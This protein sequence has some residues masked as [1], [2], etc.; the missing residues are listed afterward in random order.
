MGDAPWDRFEGEQFRDELTKYK[1]ANH[2]FKTHPFFAELERGA[3]PKPVVQAWVKQFYPWLAS[4]PV[5]MAERF[6]NCSW[7]ASNDRYRRMILD[8]LVEEAGDPKGKEPGHP[9]LWLRFCEGIGVPRAEV[10][11]A[12]LLPSTMVAIDDFLYTNRIN[13]FFVSAAGS[14]EP[15]NVDLCARLLPAFR[16]HYA[17]PEENLEY[18]R[19]H[20][21]ADVEHS[22]W[23]GQI[24]AGF[25]NNASVRKQMW[26]QMLRGFSIHALLVDGVAQT[27]G[28]SPAAGKHK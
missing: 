25:A 14:S 18:Y 21:T 12:S 23:I 19:L 20:V 2:P 17:V 7:E 6:A 11:S 5:A 16:T 28:W 15:P 4:V 22:E 13:T 27:T 26:E 9:E 3:V 8:Q 1:M 24:V 10:Q